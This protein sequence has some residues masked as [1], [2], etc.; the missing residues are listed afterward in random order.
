MIVKSSNI[1]WHKGGVSQSDRAKLLNQKPMLLWFTGL[2]GSGKSTV[3]REVENQLFQQN[4]LVYVL[5]GDNVRFGLNRD[6]SFSLGDRK[7]N[8]RR[9][10]ETA[11]LMVDAG[12]IIICAFISPFNQDRKDIREK[13]GTEN[14]VEIYVKCS[15]QECENRDVKGLYKLARKGEINNFTGISSPYEE[16]QNPEIVIDTDKFSIEDSTNKVIEYLKERGI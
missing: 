8:I 1:K 12:F 6:L 2:S 3:A 5:D 13:V 10:G 16:P 7:E 11:K 4:K 9:I 15:L 14:F